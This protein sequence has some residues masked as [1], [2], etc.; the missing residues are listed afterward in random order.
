MSKAIVSFMQPTSLSEAMEAARVMAESTLVPATFQGK[1]GDILIAGQMAAELGVSWMQGLQNIAVINGRP[2]IWGDLLLALVM[3]HP[4]FEDITEEYD[5]ENKVATCTIKRKNM[6]SSVTQTFSWE[7]AMQAGLHDKDTYKKYP[8]RMLQMRARS[9]AVRDCMPDALRGIPVAE[10]IQY[11]N[12]I[13]P[14]KVELTETDDGVAKL[15]E[16]IGATEA[17][18]P[19]EEVGDTAL[20]AWLHTI[21][22]CTSLPD[23]ETIGAQIA[24]AELEDPDKVTLRTEFGRKRE[25]LQMEAADQKHEAQMADGEEGDIPDFFGAQAS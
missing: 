12:V 23:L 18:P 6:A 22:G 16:A 7:D 19:P 5:D 14:E 3:A 11:V 4:Q 1:P 17:L 8:R 15:K 9:W 20:D 13:E 10:E 24:G 2:A 21:D 25:Q